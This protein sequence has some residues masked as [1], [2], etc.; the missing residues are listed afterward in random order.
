VCIL[1]L[2]GLAITSTYQSRRVARERDLATLEQ[3]K[4]EKVVDLL[5]ELF[6]ASNPTNTPR[7]S[8]LTVGEFLRDTEKSIL[9]NQGLDA[10]VQ[11]RLKHV[12]GQAY[13]VRGQFPQ[14]R[15]MLEEALRQSRAA[16]G[17]NHPATTAVFHNLV[18]LMAET[19]SPAEALPLLR[20]CLRR[21]RLLL[22]DRHEKVA[23]CLQNLGAALPVSDEQKRL[24]EQALS[25]RQSLGTGP[26]VGLASSLNALGVYYYRTGNL[27]QQER[28][29]EET[30]SVLKKVYPEGHPA[31]LAVE[32]NLAVVYVQQGRFAKAAERDAALIEIKSR[33]L[34]PEH[35]QV[36]TGYG[37]LGTDLAQKGDYIKAEDSFRRALDLLVKLFGPEHA[38]VANA[39]RNLG[40]I[41]Q[42]RGDYAQASTLLRRGVELQGRA[43]NDEAVLWNSEAELGVV[44]FRL[45]QR[46]EGLRKLTTAVEKLKLLPSNAGA[47]ADSQVPLGY[48]L[49]ESGR[50]REAEPLFRQ[51]SAF[52]RAKLPANHPKIAEAECGLGW[53][54]AIEGRS[55]EAEASLA[56][57]LPVLRSWGL[58][59][60]VTV[61]QLQGQLAELRRSSG[62]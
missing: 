6:A 36:A 4:T 58:A 34:G 41:R 46:R 53:A 44:L 28:Y 12:L 30:L 26:T 43:G 18:S 3:Q 11:A 10:A 1:L 21:H 61:R 23:A 7:G 8:E 57:H 20:E 49:L 33:L 25:I 38:Q 16:N 50:V 9:G 52:R 31:S 24:L 60:P 13:R 19:G 35:P 15:F 40:R 48:A 54:L 45:G 37:N 39:T 5:V 47:L 22:G 14:A 62:F 56:R 27:D 51:A 59:D 17:E 42:L 29:F 2:A 32:H 55:R